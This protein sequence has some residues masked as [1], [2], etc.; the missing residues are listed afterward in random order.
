MRV[1]MSHGFLLMLANAKY[2]L[3]VISIAKQCSNFPHVSLRRLWSCDYNARS[4][5][6]S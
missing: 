3:T 2:R 6:R 4:F 5:D 1:P